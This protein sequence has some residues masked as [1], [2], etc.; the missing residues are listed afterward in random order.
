MK[1]LIKH[2]KRWNVWRKHNLNSPWHHILVLFGI[3]K[4]PT[5]ELFI[6]PG[7]AQSIDDILKKWT[8]RR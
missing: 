7:E 2:F 1:K 3:V 5:F 6:L 4:S 8:D